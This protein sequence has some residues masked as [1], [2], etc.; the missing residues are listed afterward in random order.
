MPGSTPAEGESSSIVPSGT[1]NTIGAF[2]TAG[3]LDWVSLMKLPFQVP[4]GMLSRISAAQVDPYTIIV[5]Q[6]LGHLFQLTAEGQQRIL[7]ALSNLISFQTL[8][9]A[10]T[11]G[12][13]IEQLVHVLA[14]T[15]E[16]KVCIALC[17][18]LPE[19]YGKS[20]ASE[21][22]ID[23]VKTSRAP[24]ELRPSILEWSAL[25]DACAGVFAATD[26]PTLAE[27][28]MQMH[29]EHRVLG[30]RNAEYTKTR[31]RGCS[32]A[33]SLAKALLA[34]AQ[35][36]R[37]D[38]AS[39]TIVGGADAGWLA[40]FAEWFFGLSIQIIYGPTN[41]ILYPGSAT[42]HDAQ[43][44]IVYSGST[45]A[46]KSNILMTSEKTYR[47]ADATSLIRQENHGDYAEACVA[48]RLE[49][50]KILA[51]VFGPEFK[52]FVKIPHAVGGALGS[53]ARIFQ[54]VALAESSIKPLYRYG[55]GHYNDGSYGKGL[56]LN[57]LH[58]FSEL[59]AFKDHMEEAVRQD[60]SSA[61]TNYEA[62]MSAIELACNCRMCRE[63][64]VLQEDY[65]GVVLIEVV[66]VIARAFSM[67]A[68]PI[69]ILPSRLGVEAVYARQVVLWQKIGEQES[70][71][72]YLN[73]LGPAFRA[74]RAQ[75]KPIFDA[76]QIFCGRLPASFG[77]GDGTCAFSANGI[78]G[79]Y[80]ALSELSDDNESVTRVVVVPGRIEMHKK[81][82]NHVTDI[83]SDNR[84][85]VH[86]WPDALSLEDMSVVVKEK[87]SFLQIAFEVYGSHL[88]NGR[89][90]LI[91][92]ADAI[93]KFWNRRGLVTCTGVGCTIISKDIEIKDERPGYKLCVL[94]GVEIEVYEVNLLQRW[95]LMS[96]KDIVNDNVFWTSR[97]CIDCCLRAAVEASQ[98]QI[99]RRSIVIRTEPADWAAR[100]K[101]KFLGILGRRDKKKS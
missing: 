9:R 34:L 85:T 15:E 88:D 8:C 6:N 40:A 27:R 49:W 96:T 23:M 91:L 10:L 82:Y 37:G 29:P 16:G 73:E 68:L 62:N 47:L 51:S 100:K 3:Q 48:G 43:I 2:S 63:G 24:E 45:N 86:G 93:Q 79:Y 53:L 71:R 61:F 33:E 97:E 54:A 4:I 59:A 70:E 72:D 77:Q 99:A 57:I 35:V 1:S 84:A 75:P 92:P 60:L 101:P 18:S 25:I 12:V 55:Y 94:A 58:Q 95:I 7:E 83:T 81:A 44:L 38:L 31:V 11:I 39:L 14:R 78:C 32:S 74:V 65:C 5:A 64:P 98:G 46:D 66:A 20:T 50:N 87:Y 56:I 69:K 22:L 89:K 28:Y 67:V 26:L 21:V 42:A 52:K 36:T 30:Y 17:G 90:S 19:F 76:M 41:E 13:G 80:K